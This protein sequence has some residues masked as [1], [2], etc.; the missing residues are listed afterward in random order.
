MSSAITLWDAPW[1]AR[2]EVE[3]S[4]REGRHYDPL[5]AFEAILEHS[6]LPV[7]ILDHDLVIREVS[8]PAAELAGM[9][10][11][12]MRGRRLGDGVRRLLKKRLTQVGAGRA[13]F[14]AGPALPEF[15]ES[16]GWKR[17]MMLPIRD[18]AGVV[19][20][21]ALMAV[22]QVDAEHTEDLV[23]K[24]ALIDAVTELPNRTMLSLALEKALSGAQLRHGQLALVWLNIDRF[25]DVNDALGQRA[26]DGL[27]RAVGERLHEAV[28]R[29]DVVARVGGDDFVL[30]L[31]RITSRKHVERLMARIHRAFDAPFASGDEAV[32]LSASG[33]VAVHPNGGA[34]ARAL[35]E[36]AHTAMRLAKGQGGG[37]FEMYDAGVAVEG[38]GRLWLAGEIR[39]G[40]Q[41]GEFILQYQPQIDLRTMRAPAVE[42]LAR[43]KHPVRGLLAP[44]QFIPFAEE[45]GL[46]VPLG[47]S[48]LQQACGHLKG[49]QASL[50]SP[51][52]VAVNVSAREVQRSDVCGEVERATASV[53]LTPACLEIEFTETAVLADP[54]RAGELAKCLRA[55][56][57]TVALDDFGTGYSSLTHL[58]ELPIDR[59]KIDRSFVGACPKDRSASAILVAVTHLAHDLGM[60]VVAEGVETE[61]QLDFVRAVGCDATQGYHL[62]R[63][64]AHADCTEYLQ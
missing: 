50:D 63:P 16:D 21:T 10:R 58:R 48:L 29:V 13:V 23:E 8:R 6:P 37:A 4:G 43:W 36:S 51:P 53:G 7:I 47:V 11:E 45:S 2:Q 3:R 35:R 59:V 40:I 22:G 26:G 34:D 31:P 33:G 17:T 64:L 52:R 19:W 56:G 14:Q 1:Q 55:A 32:L 12:E 41:R 15:G 39:D 9:S 54:K 18:A 46:I 44:A 24:P 57:A 5:G 28:R 38:S 61:A 30:L 42:A 27:L 20:G 25:R 49:W 60:E 62:A